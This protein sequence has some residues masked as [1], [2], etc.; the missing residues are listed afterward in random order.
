LQRAGCAGVNREEGFDGELSER[1]IQR[2]TKDH[3]G[4]EEVQHFL[5]E[6]QLKWDDSGI[7][8]I[9]TRSGARRQIVAQLVHEVD[10]CGVSSL[11]LTPE[12]LEEV[13]TPFLQIDYAWC[14]AFWMQAEA[15]HVDRRLQKVSCNAGEQRGDEA[16]GG[17]ERPVAVNDE[18]RVGLD[19][20]KHL[21]HGALC[22]AQGWVFERPL[23][24]SGGKACSEKEAVALAQGQGQLFTELEQGSAT[25]QRAAGFEETQVAGGD[26]GFTGQVKLAEFAALAPGAEKYSGLR[27]A[28]RWRCGWHAFHDT[29]SNG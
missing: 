13:L 17:N 29:E 23:R 9:R 26:P 1:N 3:G 27:Q 10:K 15:Q 6:P 25:G 21:L 19:A 16:I 22:S 24:I 18:R 5:A 8:I 12:P 28:R 4:S 20:D 14:E 2:R 11:H 7:G